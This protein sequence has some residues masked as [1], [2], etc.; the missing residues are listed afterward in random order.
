VT[1]SIVLWFFSRLMLAAKLFS[2]SYFI[3]FRVS[4]RSS[5]RSFSSKD[6]FWQACYIAHNCLW[7]STMV[8]LCYHVV[9]IPKIP[10]RRLNISPYM[11]YQF[12]LYLCSWFCNF[13]ACNYQTR[14]CINLRCDT[15]LG[16]YSCYFHK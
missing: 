14:D 7:L 15:C 4:Q 6:N 12:I 11:N 3:W 5:K 10:F 8:C 13:L 9:G 16:Y 1:L 2:S